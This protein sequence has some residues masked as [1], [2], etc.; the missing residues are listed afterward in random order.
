MHAQICY[1][2]L[3]GL[4]NGSSNWAAA[5][6]AMQNPIPVNPFGE[7]TTPKKGIMKTIVDDMKAFI[8]EHRKIIYF[9]VILLLIDRFFLKRAL[10]NRIKKMA[11]GLLGTVENK[12][13]QLTNPPVNVTPPPAP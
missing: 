9:V 3:I 10:E 2:P 6:Q 7:Q 11:E 12:L 1:G 13:H 4:S 8:A 5:S